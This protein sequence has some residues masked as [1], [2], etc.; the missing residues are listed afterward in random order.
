MAKSTRRRAEDAHVAEVRR[1]EALVANLEQTPEQLRGAARRELGVTGEA[2]K[3][4]PLRETLARHDV[5]LYSLVALGTLLVID[6]LH[7]YGFAVL[8]PEISRSLGIG[9]AAVAGVLAVKTLALSLAP[10]PVAALVQRRPRRAVLSVVTGAIWSV[11]S[12][13]TGMVLNVWALLA[14]LSVDGLTSGSVGALHTP[15]L[16]DSYPPEWRVRVLT[17]YDA[18]RSAANVVSPLAVA[19]LAGALGF[20]WRGVFV[21]LG[22]VSLLAVGVALRLEDPGFG[23]FDTKKVRAAVHDLHHEDVES[24]E[25]DVSL[26]FFEIARRLLLIPTMRRLLISYTVIGILL[27]PFQTFLF[28]FLQ[29][30]WGLGPGQRGVFFAITAAV[31]VVALA[32]FGKRGEATFRRDPARVVEQA[33]LFLAVAVVLICLAALAPKFALMVALFSCAFGLLAIITPSLNVAVLSVVP[34]KMRPHAAALNGIF[35]GGVGGLLGAILL[36]GVDRRY[37]VAGSIVSLLVPGVVGALILRSSGKF[38]PRDLDRM[39]DEVLEDEEI[40]RINSSGGHLPMLA[41]RKVSFSYGQVQVL[42]DVDF[43]VDDGEMVALLGV[44]GAGKST[45]LKVI[46]GIGLPSSGSVRFQGAEITYLDAERRV[47]LGITQ[48]PGGRAVFGRMTVLQNLRSFGWV[49]TAGRWTRR[50]TGASPPSRTCPAGAVSRRRPS[51]VVSSRCS[52]W[53]RRSCCDHGCCSSTSWRSAWRPSSWANCST[54]SAGSTTVAP[55]SCWS[56]SR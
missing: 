30:R 23:Q 48:V 46:S 11:A 15:L 39:I 36:G 18:A 44:N 41:C 8:A 50:S 55:P 2:G 47:R 37:G 12:I 14:A 24:S 26:G 16:L 45:L 25:D 6:T 43:T 13:A 56:S 17:Y 7:S 38:V 33:G 54:W 34:A 31:Q 5:S 32:L 1:A 35:L 49:V 3:A 40:R 19:L 4:S 27:I 29:E 20:T 53:P 21:I 28:F 51:R 52:G 42:F 10:L 22:S 9:K